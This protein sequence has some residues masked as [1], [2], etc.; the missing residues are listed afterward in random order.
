MFI[1]QVSILNLEPQSKQ[2]G[3]Q[4]TFL[5]FR[6]PSLVLIRKSQHFSARDIALYAIDR[7]FQT[8]K[9]QRNTCIIR[10]N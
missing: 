7:T 10:D 6:Q 3:C 5:G 4:K 2:Q 8:W 1:L 9:F